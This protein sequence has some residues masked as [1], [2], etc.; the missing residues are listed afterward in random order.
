MQILLFS[1]MLK[2]SPK[3]KFKEQFFVKM[4]EESFGTFGNILFFKMKPSNLIQYSPD[5]LK[6]PLYY[7]VCVSNRASNVNWIIDDTSSHKCKHM[8]LKLCFHTILL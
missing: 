7:I 1:G 6:L 4:N 8:A 3:K 2:F 5:V